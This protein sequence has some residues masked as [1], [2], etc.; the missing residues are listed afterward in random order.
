MDEVT[1]L[2]NIGDNMKNCFVQLRIVFQYTKKQTIPTK[3]LLLVK[4]KITPEKLIAI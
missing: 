3:S 4:I 1:Y 2:S